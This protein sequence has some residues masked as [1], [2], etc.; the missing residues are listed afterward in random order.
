MLFKTLNHPNII[1][2][3]ETEII[4]IKDQTHLLST[5]F[6]FSVALMK[7]VNISV[8][9][10]SGGSI[11]TLLNKFRNLDEKVVMIYMRQILEGLSYLHRMGI[12]H[13]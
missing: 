10:V 9:Y 7:I 11:R 3:Y 2:H 4:E 13:T 1:R 5:K 8:E 12:T 6:N